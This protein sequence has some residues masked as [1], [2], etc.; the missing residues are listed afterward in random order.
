M[1][2]HQPMALRISA[3]AGAVAV[4]LGAFGA[5]GLED[6]LTESGRRETWNTA[7]LY[8]MVHSVVLLLLAMAATWRP[9]TWGLVFAGIALFAGSLYL[10]CLTQATWLGAVTPVGGLLLI[11]GWLS[12][13]LHPSVTMGTR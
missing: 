2:L 13:L 10:L 4:G 9:K 11:A 12:L 3:V 5:H 1:T 7:V 6:F 8:H